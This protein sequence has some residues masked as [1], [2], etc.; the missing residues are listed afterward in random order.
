MSSTKIAK[1]VNAAP[2]DENEFEAFKEVGTSKIYDFIVQER[3][4]IHEL[5]VDGKSNDYDSALGDALEI[6]FKA[7][8]R[9]ASKRCF[10]CKNE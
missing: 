4:R 7:M 3:D 10:R 2:F 6:A 9:Y 8:S 1:T 5:I